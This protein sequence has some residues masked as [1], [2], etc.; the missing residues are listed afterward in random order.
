MSIKRCFYIEI[1]LVLK[2]FTDFIFPIDLHIIQYINKKNLKKLYK[3][4]YIIANKYFSKIIIIND[5]D[6]FNIR[7]FHFFLDI[8]RKLRIV[9]SCSP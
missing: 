2:K 9:K 4:Y 5:N 7:D 6:F 1:F 3:N 8:L